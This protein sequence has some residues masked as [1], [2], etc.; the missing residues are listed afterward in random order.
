ME[1]KLEDDIHYSGDGRGQGMEEENPP[2]LGLD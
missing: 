2:Y 1:K